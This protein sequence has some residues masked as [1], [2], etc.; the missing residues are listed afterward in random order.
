[1]AI[2]TC[3]GILQEEGKVSKLAELVYSIPANHHRPRSLR[4]LLSSA[5]ARN[6]DG[7][8]IPL[9]DRVRFANR[10]A[11]A[12]L[13]VHSG[14]FVHKYIRPENIIVFDASKDDVFPSGLGLPFLVGFS[15]SRAVRARTARVGDIALSECM[16]Q[17]P[18][19]WGETAE[20]RFQ[21]LHDVYSL[22]V[23]LL[24]IGIWESFIRW[25]TKEYVYW[26]ELRVITAHG[27]LG[28]DF[29]RHNVRQVFIEKA[30]TMLPSRMGQ[31][32]T[33]VVI[34]CLSSSVK[35]NEGG[36]VGLKFIESVVSQLEK[37][38]V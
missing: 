32:Y 24:E 21:M 10:L 13:Y 31:R 38:T 14:Q 2:L 25:D 11:T 6:E 17:H 34:E 28:A 20:S 1:M 5:D 8:L 19:R 4:S 36:P 30:Q 9:N 37:L 29:D 35:D 27:A 15:R 18:D 22:G 16:Y 33:D 26:K 3:C 12:V 7:I 23:V